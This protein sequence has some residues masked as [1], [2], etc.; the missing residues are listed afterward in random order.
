MLLVDT[1]P[2]VRFAF[3]DYLRTQGFLVDTAGSDIA[4]ELR[5]RRERYHVMISDL[6][7]DQPD[8]P[9][10]IRLARQLLLLAPD[11]VVC[12]LTRPIDAAT[13]RDAERIADVVLLRPRPLADITQIVL[14]LIAQRNTKAVAHPDIATPATS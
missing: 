6:T 3:A 7:L 13:M 11:T 2:G 14:T 10:G 1:D 9:G 12:L 4:A 8:A 5:L